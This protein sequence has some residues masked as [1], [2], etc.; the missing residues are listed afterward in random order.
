MFTARYALTAVARRPARSLFLSGLLGVTLASLLLATGLADATGTLKSRVLAPLHN[1]GIDLIITSGS[2]G[3]A[4]PVSGPVRVDSTGLIPGKEF[5]KDEFLVD[6]YWPVSDSV[7]SAL[8]STADV[9]SFS[10]IL[11]LGCSR[12]RG[13]A[14]DTIVIPRMVIDPLSSLEKAQIDRAVATD[15]DYQDAEQELF[16]LRRRQCAG[17]PMDERRMTELAQKLVNIEFSY[18]PERLKSV[19]TETASPDPVNA[20]SESFLVAGISCDGTTTNASITKLSALL[21]HRRA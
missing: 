18:Y 14:P 20:E 2:P 6:A 5:T 12:T 16:E 7:A 9:S 17:L 3:E 1:A 8:D 10:E 11:L 15:K 4:I 19:A 13:V 21:R